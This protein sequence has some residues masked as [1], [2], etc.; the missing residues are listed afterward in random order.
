MQLQSAKLFQERIFSAVMDRKP[1]SKLSGEWSL[2]RLYLLLPLEENH[3][4][5]SVPINWNCIKNLISDVEYILPEE[6]D[7]D[8][9]ERSLVRLCDGYVPVDHVKNSVVQTVH[10][11]RI[12]CAG[13]LIPN[14][15]AE[16]PMVAKVL[17]YSSYSDYYEQ[18]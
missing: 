11:D 18:R 17:K 6:I 5:S 16:S 9:P 12:Y 13:E 14:L 8:I 15:T 10:N 7:P 2:D 4:I 1:G 3:E